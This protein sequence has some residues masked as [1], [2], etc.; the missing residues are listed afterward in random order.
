MEYYASKGANK[1]KLVMGIPTY[2]QSFTLHDHNNNGLNS[3]ASKGQPGKYTRAAGFLAYNEVT[4]KSPCIT[5]YSNLHL[6]A[7]FFSFRSVRKCRMTIGIEF[8]THR[9]PWVLMPSRAPNGWAMTMW[10]WSGASP[11]SLKLKDME[12]L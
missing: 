10:P 5:S 1:T 4:R 8:T 3:P 9:M 12:V 6:T 2:G 11:S 7:H